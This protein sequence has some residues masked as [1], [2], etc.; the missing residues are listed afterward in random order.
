MDL[1][2]L[3]TLL[4][5]HYWARD[6]MLTALEPLAPEQYTK[7]LGSSFPSL[8]DTAVHILSA[9]RIWLSR[10]QGI[11]PGAHTAPAELPDV[12]ALRAAWADTEAGVRRFLAALGED[13][14]QRR[15]E[16]HSLTGVKGDQRFSQMLQ[17][18]VNHASYHRGQVTTLLRQLGAAPPKQMDLL[19]FQRE[20]SQ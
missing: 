16:Y 17:H 15:I 2:D 12:A 14:V 4:D 6:R 20:T 11:S 13:G 7:D 3:Q 5:Y 1:A 18:V 9:E 10:W 19:A 8:R